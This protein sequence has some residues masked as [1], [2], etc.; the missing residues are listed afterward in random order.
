MRNG[1]YYLFFLLWTC[2]G[3]PAQENLIPAKPNVLVIFTDQQN[4]EMMSA[5]GNTNLH[6]PNMDRLA[7]RGVLFRNFYCT[8]PVCAPARSSIITG[9]M[10]HQTGVE[11]NGD[12][13]RPGIKNVGEI[14]RE[15]G[16][17]TVWGGKWHLPESYPLQSKSKQK[18]IPGF[19][20][21]P[22]Q[23]P[24]PNR[25]ML[26]SETDPPLTEA[27]V[28]FLNHYDKPEPF[29]LSISYHNPHDICFYARKEGWASAEDS[30]LNIRYY[31]FEYKLP[32]VISTHPSQVQPLPELPENH[33][34]DPGEPTF[35]TDKRKY[36]KEYGLETHLANQE[37]GDLEWKGYLNAYYRLTEMVDKEIGKVLDALD[38]N[39]LDENTIIIFT[40]DHGDG[41]AAH[42]WSAKLSLY[43]ESAAVPF[44]ISW[45]GFIPENKIDDQHLVSQA[46]IVPTLCDLAGIDSGLDFTGSSIRTILS[47]QTASWRD[48][49][50]VELADY[51]P[52]AS[53]K[54]RMVRTRNYKYNVYS[55]G[56]RTEQ[57]FDLSMD[58]GEENNLVYKPE[59]AKERQRHFNLLQ[60]WMQQTNDHFI[61][62]IGKSDN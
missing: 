26:G 59:Y 1:Y 42:K 58:P 15:A 61:P 23:A 14:F 12:T 36:H 33:A 54:G 9:L 16:Y 8:S 24:N 3:S 28:D 55:T 44:M 41:A 2:A 45:P 27:V 62:L 37:F 38:A 40:S 52:D 51:K 31:N 5:L 30:L 57:L 29:F 10:P 11:W 4:A 25:W 50:I 7:Q 17:H 6:T 21:L 46:D 19:D 56:E 49:L 13:I 60:E 39:G 48:H 43:Q 35:V 47:D 20:L 34:I 22:F 18:E 32:A 53:R